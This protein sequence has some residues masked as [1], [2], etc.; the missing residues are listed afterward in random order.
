MK[1]LT[2][3]NHALKLAARLIIVYEAHIG[4]IALANDHPDHPDHPDY[5]AN[6]HA[7]NQEIKKALLS[8]YLWEKW[9]GEH[10]QARAALL[11]MWAS[12]EWTNRDTCA[13]LC[14]RQAGFSNMA[15]ARQALVGAPMPASVAVKRQRTVWK[16]P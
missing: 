16:A 9:R 2:Q 10:A 5:Q 12:G 4:T 15:I 13:R 6:T 14:Y 8:F 11:A 7:I 1:L 3:H